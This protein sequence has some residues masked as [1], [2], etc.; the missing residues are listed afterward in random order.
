MSDGAVDDG[1]LAPQG[2]LMVAAPAGFLPCRQP[3]GTQSAVGVHIG[4][5]TPHRTRARF[6]DSR[7]TFFCPARGGTRRRRLRSAGAVPTPAATVSNGACRYSSG[8]ALP[9][10]V[11]FVTWYVGGIA[12]GVVLIIALVTVAVRGMPRDRRG[13]SSA[14]RGAARRR[15]RRSR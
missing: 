14:T 6:A 13:S 10:R 7:V 12:I 5:H 9:G 15:G 1:D 11:R 8:G 3:S 2:R 4:V